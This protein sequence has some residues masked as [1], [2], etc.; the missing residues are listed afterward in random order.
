M[1][2][3]NFLQNGGFPFETDIFDG[4]Q[5]A[6]EIF[7]SLGA[8]AG[9]LTIISGCVEN[10]SNV[11]DGFVHINGEILHFIGGA[12][13]TNVIIE[14]TTQSVE[15]QDQSTREIK[16]TRVAKFGVGLTV[17]PWENFTRPNTT[18]QL[19]TLLANLTQRVTDLE[20][21]PTSFVI[22]MVMVWNRPANEIPLGWE[23]YT[24]MRG[25][26]PVGLNPNYV[27]GTDRTHYNLEVLGYAGGSREHQLT[28][29]EMPAHNHSAPNGFVSH[30]SGYDRDNGSGYGY[31]DSTYDTGGNQ[32]HTN[33]SPYRVVHF[34]K[35]VGLNN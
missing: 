35:Y 16:K 10:G 11:S 7:H 31:N 26:M 28:I 17:Y 13:G 2:T 24:E 23:E 25:R 32:A 9:D 34:I 14:E 12:I 21:I 8:L 18:T 4:M 33:M 6:Y 22:G 15:F 19:T 3:Y 27:Q 30:G 5:K 29:A 1:N 20:N